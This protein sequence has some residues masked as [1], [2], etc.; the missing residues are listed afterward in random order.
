V[1]S[2][3]SLLLIAVVG[4]VAWCLGYAAGRRAYKSQE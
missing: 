2:F 1:N 4:V 3:F